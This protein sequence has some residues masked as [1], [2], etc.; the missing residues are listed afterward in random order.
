MGRA[1]LGAAVGSQDVSTEMTRA[2]AALQGLVG[3]TLEALSMGR[4]TRQDAALLGRVVSKL[5]PLVGNLLE[6]EVINLLSSPKAGVPSGLEWRRQDP[7]F[8]DAGLF[9]AGSS[10][11]EAGFEVKAWYVPSTEI[12]GRFRESLNLLGDKDIRVVIVAWMM[13]DVIFGS[14]E[15]LGVLSV[16]A[17]QLASARDRHYH[18]PP[19]YLIVEPGDTAHRTRNLQQSTVSGY[20]WQSGS[21]AD[22]RSAQARIDAYARSPESP[23]GMAEQ[24]LARELQASYEYRLDTN[25]AKID[26]IDDPDVEAFKAAMLARQERGRT[27]KSWTRVIK[28]LQSENEAERSAAEAVVRELYD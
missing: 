22:L 5:S 17:Q 12:T 24:G 18:N 28:H 23:H 26:R 9:R 7:D 8:P 11:L 27:L 15:V 3:T 14:P 20:K 1:L 10:R 4:M 13:S 21:P 16:P 19:S 2:E 6:A 25:F